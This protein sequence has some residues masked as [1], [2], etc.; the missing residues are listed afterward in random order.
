M[1]LQNYKNAFKNTGKAFK[2]L[3][4]Y[5]PQ[6]CILCGKAGAI[7]CESCKESLLMHNGNL[8]TKCGKQIASGELCYNCKKDNRPYEKGFMVYFYK[9]NAKKLMYDFKF[10]GKRDISY[11]FAQSLYDKLKIQDLEIDIVTAV[12]M[13]IIKKLGKGYNPPV[14]IAKELSTLINKPFD[15]KILK[16]IRHTKAMS[17]MHDIDRMEHSSKNYSFNNKNVKDK[18]ILI[19]D[20]VSTTGATLHVCAQIL[21]DNGAE[22]VYVAAACGGN[23]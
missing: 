2:K 11:F 21:K 23:Y 7:V 17:T 19:I 1:I 4:F 10:E 14:L 12:P 20:D 6:E 22:K 5:A 16:R 9:D 18:N 13:H 3:L 8:C 15:G